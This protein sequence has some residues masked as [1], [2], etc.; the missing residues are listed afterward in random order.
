MET[1][2]INSGRGDTW[3]PGGAAFYL[4]A[5]RQGRG[6]IFFAGL[7]GAAL[8]EYKINEQ[9][10]IEHFKNEYGRLRDV[11]LGPDNMLYITTSNRD[12]RGKPRQGDDKILRWY[13]SK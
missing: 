4:P 5:G 9:K 6:S 2:V 3:A 1:P 8:Y 11:V 13:N 12:G 7:R 10:L